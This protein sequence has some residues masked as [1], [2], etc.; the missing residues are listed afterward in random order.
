MEKIA[1][2]RLPQ[3]LARRGRGRSAHYNDI[4][5]G[6]WTRPVQIGARC[7]AW[8]AHESDALI[9]ARIAGANDD[10]IRQLVERLHTDRMAAASA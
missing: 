8:P 6:L 5:K 7:A 9:R 2:E 1:L 3:L 10:D 4:T